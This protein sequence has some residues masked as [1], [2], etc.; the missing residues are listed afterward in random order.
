MGFE[1]TT[2]VVISTDCTCS[3]E[4][5][6]HTITTTTA[7]QDIFNIVIVESHVIA[8]MM[9]FGISS[10][11]CFASDY[12]N[13]TNCILLRTYFCRLLGGPTVNAFKITTVHSAIKYRFIFYKQWGIVRVTRSLYVMFC[14]SLFVLLSFFFCPLCCLSFFDL[15]MDFVY[16]FGIF[17]PLCCLS[18]F[19]LLMDSVYPFGIFKLFS[20]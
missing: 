18:F 7:S 5:N 1:L 8:N 13:D 11:V 14:R 19:D 10:L 20:R 12:C 4:S 6:Y 16:P 3:C 2:L 17:W 15:L 9:W